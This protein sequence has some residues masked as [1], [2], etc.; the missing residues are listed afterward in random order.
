MLDGNEVDEGGGELLS[1]CISEG[2]QVYDLSKV[3]FYFVGGSLADAGEE[4]GVEKIGCEGVGEE[5]R[6]EDMREAA[7]SKALQEER[8]LDRR[9]DHAR[10]GGHRERQRK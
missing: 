3:A 8:E 10:E 9:H 5:G 7:D 6:V 2:Y 1:D 4:E